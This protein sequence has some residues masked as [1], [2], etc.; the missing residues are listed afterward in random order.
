ME[1]LINDIVAKNQ[2]VWFWVADQL[3][4]GFYFDKVTKKKH[5]LDAGA[6][7]ALDPENR[8]KN[9]IWATGKGE[10][11]INRYISESDYI[12]IISGS[13]L[14]SKL[15]NKRVFELLEKRFKNFNDFKKGILENS[16]TKDIIELVNSFDSWESFKES[17]KRKELLLAIDAQKDKNTL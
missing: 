17:P 9:I 15:F 4:R 14:I 3:G 5:Y 12:F 16:K 8:D 11:S 7:F 6:S 13:P 2:K 10:K 1:V